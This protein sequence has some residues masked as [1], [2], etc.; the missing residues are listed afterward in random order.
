MFWSSTE[1]RH[2][3][4]MPRFY[5][6]FIYLVTLHH[7]GNYVNAMNQTSYKQIKNKEQIL[8]KWTSSSSFEMAGILFII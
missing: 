8:K 2:V 6:C 7:E 4:I 1:D 5:L 3:D